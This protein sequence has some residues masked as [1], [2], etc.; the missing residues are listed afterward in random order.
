MAAETSFRPEIAEI[1]LALAVENG[2]GL[3]AIRK[4]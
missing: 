1:L 2:Y 3:L 4:S